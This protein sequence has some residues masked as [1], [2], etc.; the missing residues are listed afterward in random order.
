MRNRLFTFRAFANRIRDVLVG[1]T[2]YF[3]DWGKNNGIK[4]II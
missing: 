4:S 2:S 1:Y 3:L